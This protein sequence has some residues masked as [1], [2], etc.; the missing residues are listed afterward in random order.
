VNLEKIHSIYFIGIGGIGMS[1]LARYF[2]V[3]GRKISGYDKT[4]TSLTD[5]LINE[6]MNIHF[7]ENES[8]IPKEVDLVVYTPA[9]PQEHKELIYYQHHHY[10]VVKRSELL[11][12]L[13]R[14]LFT[15]AVAGTHGK[16]TTSSMIAHVLRNAG[17]DCTAFLGGI[18]ANYNSNFI[19]GKGN[20]CVV[21]ADEY[22][23][24]FLKL[25]PD[26]AIVTSC[27][28]D[29]LDIYL[30]EEE[31]VNAYG[32]FANQIKPNGQLIT[33]REL[34]FL[35][36][37]S[38]VQPLYYSVSG[39]EDF[40]ATNIELLNGTY[41]FDFNSRDQIIPRIHLNVAGHHNLENAIAAAAVA[42]QLQ[43]SPDKIRE[44]L[45]TFKG[46]KRRFEFI[47]RSEKI[48]YIDDYAHHPAE[49]SAFLNSV[50]EIFPGKKITCIFQPH[51]FSR[52]RDFANAFSNALS[53]AD[54]VILL[55]IY[56]ARELPID[57][58]SSQILLNE[59]SSKE[60]RVVEKEDLIMALSKSKNELV[61]TI[62]AGDIDQL[63][64]SIKDYLIKL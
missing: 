24:S 40:F 48:V 23:R 43:V 50:K 20:V 55:P 47:L 6:G 60:K 3:N 45:N 54:D 34:P 42:F 10:H 36:Y 15:V 30:T 11:E 29:H 39:K 25:H 33:K 31:V 32:E 51:L 61:V 7:D 12:A 35:P 28:P 9:I 58:V 27:D 64:E 14:N 38:K 52:T 5:E 16:T 1:A 63:T 44:G 13:T 26:I 57:G 8:L 18:T 41:A 49:I 2:H 59:I 21:E 22:D 53:I 4:S 62:G 37:V 56:P 17:V 19:A 46:V